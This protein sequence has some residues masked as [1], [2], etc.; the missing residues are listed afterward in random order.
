MAIDPGS[1]LEL[2]EGFQKYHAQPVKFPNGKTYL[3]PVLPLDIDED[4]P[5]EAALLAALDAWTQATTSDE[6]VSLLD[7]RKLKRDVARAALGCV[8]A[9]ELP[10]NMGLDVNVFQR[11]HQRLC[12][13][14]LG[15]V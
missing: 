9:G 4:A 14:D 12:G 11:L 3:C 15:K 8:Y 10:E 2:R 6:G 7:M 13:V 1:G 5:H